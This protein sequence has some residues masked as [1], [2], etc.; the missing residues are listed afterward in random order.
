MTS[1]LPYD[2]AREYPDAFQLT[3]VGRRSA[4]GNPPPP[5]A[6]S[7]RSRVGSIASGSYGESECIGATEQLAG[8]SSPVASAADDRSHP[9][10]ALCSFSSS[11]ATMAGTARRRKPGR[12]LR[13]SAAPVAVAPASHPSV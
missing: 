1:N 6:P 13:T 3:P 8:S 10:V 5:S 11:A 2:T 7:R 4:H 9:N 12:S